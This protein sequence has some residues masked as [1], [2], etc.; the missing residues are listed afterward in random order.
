MVSAFGRLTPRDQP[1]ADASPAALAATESLAPRAM[2]DDQIICNQW[3]A[4]DLS[5]EPGDAV[6]MA[7][8]VMNDQL[9]FEEH[10]HSLSVR[11]VVPMTGAA[12]DPSLM[13]AFPGLAEAKSCRE[14]EPGIPVDL[15]KLDDRDQEYWREY[16]G[17]PKA[18]V[19]LTTG[20]QLWGNRF[21]TLTAVRAAADQGHHEL[22]QPCQ[23][24]PQIR[25]RPLPH[26][27]RLAAQHAHPGQQRFGVGLDVQVTTALQHISQRLTM[28]QLP[29]LL[30]RPK[31]RG[32]RVDGSAP[33]QS[34]RT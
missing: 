5:L 31:A 20:R 34:G 28:M 11:A 7:Y 15:Q 4:E 23:R 6:E 17:T 10:T 25:Q 21:G 33:Q 12:A 29:E 3:L 16:K 9:Q 13:P 22:R 30:P 14:W 1:A 32:P 8:W 18:F 2:R 19:T 24:R 27:G 26:Q